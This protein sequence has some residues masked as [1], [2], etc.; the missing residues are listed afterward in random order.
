MRRVLP[1][2]KTANFDFGTAQT[3]SLLES[4]ATVTHLE[5]S[6]EMENGLLS[7][8]LFVC[9]LCAVI[10][11]SRTESDHLGGSRTPQN[12]ELRKSEAPETTAT[13]SDGN[14]NYTESHNEAKIVRSSRNGE[15]DWSDHASD[16]DADKEGMRN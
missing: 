13:V 16:E 12:E 11:L 14:V 3:S 5:Q 2:W 1:I 15:G 6:I 10:Q 4:V 7:L 9:Y 8:L